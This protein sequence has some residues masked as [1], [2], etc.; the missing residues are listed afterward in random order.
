MGT[1]EAG[2]ALVQIR[3]VDPPLVVVVGGALQRVV[4]LRRPALAEAPGELGLHRLVPVVRLVRIALHGLRPAVVAADT[5]DVRRHAAGEERP[6]QVGRHAFQETFEGDLVQV[7]VRIVAGEHMA[8]VVADVGNLHRHRVAQLAL[9]GDVPRV[10]RGR[11]LLA[12]HDQR[13]DAVGPDEGPIRVRLHRARRRR[14]VRQIE[15]RP[16][17]A[18]AGH[19]LRRQHRQVL[20]DGVTEQRAE[21]ADVVA[22]AVTAADDRLV[23]ELIRRAEARRP[24][25][26]V[27][28]V[29]AE[30]DAA[31]AP[32]RRPPG[33]QV[34]PRPVAGL[35]DGLRVDMSRRSP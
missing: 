2:R 15:D 19:V 30:I 25:Q 23:V 27:L 7:L 4:Q 32:H 9:Q 14:P 20:G 35:V 29:A 17:L 11:P 21:D 8:A 10:H 1:V 12:R 24:V 3:L 28:D 6:P 13:L 26:A 31:H 34:D 18:R 16:E 5:E 22:A 33:G